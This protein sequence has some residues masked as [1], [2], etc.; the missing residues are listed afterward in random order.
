[1]SQRLCRDT[2]EILRG[3]DESHL[4]MAPIQAR[5]HLSATHTD[6]TLDTIGLDFFDDVVESPSIYRDPN[7]R[8]LCLLF[9]GHC[10]AIV[11][12]TIFLNLFERARGNE[13]LEVLCDNVAL[14][15][16]RIP[17]AFED[18]AT[19]TYPWLVQLPTTSANTTDP[20][21]KARGAFA[22]SLAGCPRTI[23]ESTMTKG[24]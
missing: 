3:I 10:F 1:M 12:V 19:Q 6:E 9:E 24:I 21:S 14:K 13:H 15:A 17:A 23:R 5:M 11:V 20:F 7:A 22:W 2:V 8:H 16:T 18:T 4:P